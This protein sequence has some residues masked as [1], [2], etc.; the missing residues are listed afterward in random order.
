MYSYF[1]ML[2]KDSSY[3][4]VA[5]FFLRTQQKTS[6]P[7]GISI[8]TIKR[9]TSEGSKASLHPESAEPLFTSPRKC[10][11]RFKYATGIDNVDQDIARRTVHEFIEKKKRIPEIKEYIGKISRKN[12]LPRVKYVNVENFEVLAISVQK[13][14]MTVAVS[15]WKEMTSV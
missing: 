15:L 11:K 9:I 1:K 7:W 12:Q 8:G 3:P 6:E 14:V 5:K 10:L 2:S 13:N 4:E